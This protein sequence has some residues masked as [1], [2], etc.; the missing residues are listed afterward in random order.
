MIH[1]AH[2]DVK[3]LFLCQHSSFRPGSRRL[4]GNLYHFVAA[5]GADTLLGVTWFT[6]D[7]HCCAV[8]VVSHTHA[9]HR[10][11]VVHI[12]LMGLATALL[13]LAHWTL[14]LG[15][16]AC[17]SLW[18]DDGV[19]TTGMTHGARGG[20]IELWVLDAA[21][22]LET[23][24]DALGGN[25]IYVL[26]RSPPAD[27]LVGSLDKSTTHEISDRNGAPSDLVWIQAGML[28]DGVLP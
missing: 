16:R 6:R 21:R 11:G 10:L 14:G 4:L 19:M 9:M 13:R 25:L 18:I 27:G 1:L 15:A 3:Y 20:A 24:L 2:D 17:I 26:I 23:P 28:L 7:A 5:L 12:M 8:I 22:R